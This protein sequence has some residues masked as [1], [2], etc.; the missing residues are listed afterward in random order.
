MSRSAAT[1]GAPRTM[2][3]KRNGRPM[4][5][6]NTQTMPHRRKDEGKIIININFA[7]NDCCIRSTTVITVT[8]RA[9][10]NDRAIVV[11]R[12]GNNF[13]VLVEATCVR[14]RTAG[15]RREARMSN[16]HFTMHESGRVE[17]A[18]SS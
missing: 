7:S 1:V 11:I 2:E 6:A 4:A 5:G 18:I 8:V 10:N 15:C 9:V 13:I 3:E 12:A 14:F 16:G 17:T